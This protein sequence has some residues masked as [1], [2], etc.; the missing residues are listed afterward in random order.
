MAI[1]RLEYRREKPPLSIHI[2]W[3][4]I[5]VAA[6]IGSRLLALPECLFHS[7]FGFPCLSCGSGR[8]LGS[9]CRGEVLQAIALNPLMVLSGMALFFFSLWKLTE[10]IFSFSVRVI[11]NKRASLWIRIS[12]VL[13]IGADW[14]YLIASKR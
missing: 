8:A 3:G 10:H 11:A 12:F 9:I 4:M 13:L 6:I 5:V 7:I 1:M 14:I 2:V